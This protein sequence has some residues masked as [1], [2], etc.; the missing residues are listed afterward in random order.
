[1]FSFKTSGESH[2]QA[3]IAM[4]DGLPAN[5]EIDIDFI[6]SELGRRQGGFGRGGRMKIEADQVR[7]LSGVRHGKTLGSPIS[8]M[9][10]LLCQGG[11]YD[12]SRAC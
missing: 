7:V 12:F 5:L 9:I 11:T 6:N 8:M 1:M 3:L 4:V 2:G 10:E